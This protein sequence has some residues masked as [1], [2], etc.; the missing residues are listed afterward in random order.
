M[1]TD[2]PALL[3]RH[4]RRGV[5]RRGRRRRGRA[6]ASPAAC[7]ALEAARA[8]ARVILLERAAE[9]RR[10][11][12]DGRRPLLP[13]RRHGG[14]AGDRHRGLRRGDVQVPD[15]GQPRPR[16][17]QDPRLLRGQ[18]RALRLD[19]GARA[20]EF[21]R[22]L[23]AGEGGDPARHRGP[24]VHRQRE[25]AA[26]P[27][28]GQA[29]AP[30]AQGARARATPAAPRWC[31]TCC[32]ERIAETGVEVRY[33]TGATNLVVQVGRRAAAPSS[34][35]PG[36]GSTNAASSARSAVVIAAGGFVGNADDGRGVHPRSSA[37]SCSRS[38]STLRRRARH[39][40]RR[41]GRRRAAG[42]WTSRSSPRRSTRRPS[43]S[44]GIVVN[45]EGERFVA[46]DSYHSRTSG[47]VMDQ[48]DQ[49]AY[50]IVDSRPHRAPP[51][52]RCARSSTAGRRS[53]RWRQALGHPGRRAGRDA[54]TATTRTPRAGED[55]DFHKHPDWL[56]A[57]G[58]RA[59]GAPTT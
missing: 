49:A 17:G 15:G 29:R 21:E 43:W 7:A 19:R 25:G 5:E 53:R 10:H 24:D 4:R 23:Y 54:A 20:F 12:R 47:F 59:R 28:P 52:S 57:A 37:R 56:A 30:R 8:G 35:S 18:R 2:L 9:L 44:P 32:A 27:R 45:K 11:Q 40:A 42:S 16:R 33:E 58:H 39:P 13:R 31:W 48:P 51:T 6:S 55:P 1:T 14:A 3:A 50:L 34:A 22:S 36:A 46:E 38:R 41:L 26:V